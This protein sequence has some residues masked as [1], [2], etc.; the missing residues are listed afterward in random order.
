MT[1]SLQSGWGWESLVNPIAVSQ[2]LLYPLSV[3][4]N[5]TM[6]SCCA[7]SSVCRGCVL[8]QICSSESVCLLV[9]SL[10][11]VAAP[12]SDIVWVHEGSS[13]EHSYVRYS[14]A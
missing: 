8:C 11:V 14:N 10:C 6:A 7:F 9:L 13:M 5:S 2:S 12:H 4:A 3:I 1:W